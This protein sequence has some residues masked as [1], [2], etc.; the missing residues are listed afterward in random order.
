MSPR[1]KLAETAI[2]FENS[3][4]TTLK[5]LDPAERPRE[6]LLERGPA[7]LSTAELLAIL[8]RTGTVGLMVT[9]LARDL[10][11]EYNGLSGLARV[12]AQ[13]LSQRHGL[14]PAKAAQLKAALAIAQRLVEE[15]LVEKPKIASPED[16]ARLVRVDMAPLEQEQL[17]ILLLDTKNR[18]LAIRTLYTGSLNQST[19]RIAEIFKA[20]IRE[21]AAAIAV[22]HNHPSGDPTPSPEDVRV[23][24]LIVEA[25]QLLDVD[26]IDHV[27]IAS[28]GHVSLRERRLGFGV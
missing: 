9:D 6:R 12:S 28:R 14:G 13:E 18:L 25:G 15:Q 16:I 8:L 2:A 1:R 11:R 22:V 26:V 4:S 27:I 17:R 23:T 5:D 21:N 19:V 7:A 24:K 3:S 10:L 20:A